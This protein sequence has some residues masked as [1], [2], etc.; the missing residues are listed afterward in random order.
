MELSSKPST[1][2]ATATWLTAVLGRPAD[3]S[4]RQLAKPAP[5][6]VDE[7]GRG[8]GDRVVRDFAHTGT[9]RDAL[10][11]TVHALSL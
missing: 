1:C 10:D 6:G 4:P 7:A 2:D 8:E 5:A 9:T 11:R 3:R